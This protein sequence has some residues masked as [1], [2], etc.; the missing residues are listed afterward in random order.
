MNKEELEKIIPHREPMLLIDEA[1]LIEENKAVGRY[2]VKGNEW[3]LKGHFPGNPIVPGVIL[4]EMMAQAGSVLVAEK[5]KGATPY[6]T[7]INKVKFKNKVQPGDTLDI[8]CSIIK[9]KPPLFFAQGKGYVK[10]MLC[11][12]GEFSFMLVK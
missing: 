7:G 6:F 8:E 3:F 12:T 2:F 4:C 11:V 5:I 9:S 1:S 10:G